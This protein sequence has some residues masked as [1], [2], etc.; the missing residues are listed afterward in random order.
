[1]FKEETLFILGAG[2]SYPYGYPLGK[3]LVIDIVNNINN[4]LAA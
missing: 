3:A 4:A 1:M 2:A